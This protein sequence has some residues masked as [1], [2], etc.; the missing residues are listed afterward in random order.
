MA[1]CRVGFD[2]VHVNN[3][4]SKQLALE[5][6]NDF[7]P[8]NSHRYKRLPIL[9]SIMTCMFYVPMGRRWHD[10][11]SGHLFLEQTAFFGTILLFIQRLPKIWTLTP[12]LT[13][14]STSQFYTSFIITM[15]HFVDKDHIDLFLT[16]N[17]VLIQVTLN[18]FATV[19]RRMVFVR[20]NNK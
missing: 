3:C 10:R 13:L 11:I 12:R 5:P 1:W 6:S 9:M 17:Y 19:S 7:I 14:L 15:T 2:C 18:L 4:V 8:P 20:K 16:L